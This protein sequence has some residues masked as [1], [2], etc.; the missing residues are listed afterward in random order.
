MA[1]T[2]ERIIQ[3]AKRLFSQNGIANTRLQQIADE[4]QISV[5]NL[6]YHFANK[7]EIVQGVYLQILEELSGILEIS[8]V[9]SGLDSFDIKFS[10]LY[11]FMEKN[12]FYFT[13]FW[14]IKRNYP[15][16]DG[17]IMA[18]NKKIQF[19]LKKRI[20][21]NVEK[22]SLIKEGKKKAYDLLATTLLNSINTWLP[23]QILNDKVPK[24]KKFRHYMWNLI[25]PYLTEKGK[26]EFAVVKI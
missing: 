2:K 1:T 23:M 8:K 12:I 11:R 22:G 13:N 20:T 4:T 10:N 3:N 25:Y 26:K 19:K 7:E 5:G 17:K 9:Y 15:I 16:V 18:F 14:E 21:D 6:A 24:E